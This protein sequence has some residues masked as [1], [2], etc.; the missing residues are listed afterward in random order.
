MNF[1][2][3][4]YALRLPAKAA[5]KQSYAAALKDKILYAKQILL[6]MDDG[7]FTPSFYAELDNILCSCY[8]E[9]SPFCKCAELLQNGDFDEAKI[10]F[11]SSIENVLSF[12]FDLGKNCLTS[13]FLYRIRKSD[14][15]LYF[16][17][18]LFHVPKTIKQ[19]S[20]DNRFGLED[21]PCLY[22]ATSSNLAWLESRMPFQYCISCFWQR[23]I[24]IGWKIVC[25]I[26]PQRF[27]S[28]EFS[29]AAAHPSD[30]K[31]RESQ[32]QMVLAYFRQLPLIIACSFIANSKLW[33]NNDESGKTIIPEY[34]IPNLLMT[35]IRDNHNKTNFKGVAYCSSSSYADYLRYNSFNIAI[36]AFDIDG[37]G[38][39]KTLRKAFKL[40]KPK[41]VNLA[42]KLTA[43]KST[44][45]TYLHEYYLHLNQLDAPHWETLKIAALGLKHLLPFFESEGKCEN[46]ETFYAL[47]C[48]VHSSFDLLKM[49]VFKDE[50]NH[51]LP[52][53]NQFTSDVSN[54]LHN[55]LNE[56]SYTE[57]LESVGDESK[58][59]E[60]F[61]YIE[62]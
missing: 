62:S 30:K 45:E 8:T 12:Y 26:S 50:E 47:L 5:P 13:S 14:T 9:D 2:E 54:A 52:T 25:L 56:I 20:A 46:A 60:E 32:E 44:G 21:A 24:T 22:L 33:K 3:V 48:S 59:T 15:P 4:C 38:F 19:T 55:L 34:Q 58:H 6:S 27:F 16:R 43:I 41:W 28:T 10:L 18:D 36:P 39:C 51:S 61:D 23:E 29:S 49:A 11:C 40:T 31:R 17:K 1:S 7:C 37:S 35:W 57:C 42:D 53:L